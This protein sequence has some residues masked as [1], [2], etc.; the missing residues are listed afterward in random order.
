M[1]EKGDEEG[2]QLANRS[3]AGTADVRCRGKIAP[4]QMRER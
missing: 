3:R 2:T 1:D 4:R